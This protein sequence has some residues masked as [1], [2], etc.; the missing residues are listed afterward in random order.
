MPDQF[1]IADALAEAARE[2]NSTQNLDST[3][4][5]IVETAA[6]SL[7]GIEHV[8]ISTIFRDGKVETQAG[9]DQLVWEM[10]QL[11]YELGEG[12]CL[13]AIREEGVVWVNDLRHD[14]RW[15]RYVP[16]AARRGIKAQLGLRLYAD[17]QILGGLNLYS[18]STSTIDPEVEH[19]AELYAVHAALALGWARKADHLNAAL[20]SRKVIGQ[21]IGIVMERFSLDEDRALQYLIRVSQHSNIKLRDVAQEL[22]NHHFVH[23]PDR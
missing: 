1:I 21:G 20:Q 16:V 12:P 13:Q 19:S 22:V 18:T 6:R 3:L 17:D 7:D 14:Q 11:Q 4:D 15:P 9:T 23:A 5:A 8:G 2:I 10:D